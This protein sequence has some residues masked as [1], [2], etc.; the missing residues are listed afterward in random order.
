MTH[1]SAAYYKKETHVDFGE[2]EWNK[3]YNIII[4]FKVGLEKRQG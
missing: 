1:R 2:I 3:W 4:Y